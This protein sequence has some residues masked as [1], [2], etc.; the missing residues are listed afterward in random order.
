MCDFKSSC[1]QRVRFGIKNLATCHF[2]TINFTTCQLLIQNFNNVSHS[3]ENL[4]GAR[5]WVKFFFRVRIWIKIKTTCRILEGKIY[6]AWYFE[7]VLLKRLRFQKMNETRQN[8][9]S[10]LYNVSDFIAKSPQCVKILKKVL[11]RD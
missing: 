10:E 3:E 2:R 7:S 5:F 1:S 11:G 4:P 6:N 8:T 9:N